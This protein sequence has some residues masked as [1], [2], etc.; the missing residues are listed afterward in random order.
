[1][2][3]YDVADPETPILR[4]FLPAPLDP[5]Y[6]QIAVDGDVLAVAGAT[7]VDLIRLVDGQPLA[8]PTIGPTLTP[9]PTRTPGTEPPRVTPL[10]SRTPAPTITPAIPATA[11]P[12]GSHVYLPMLMRRLDLRAELDT[13]EYEVLRAVIVSQFDHPG[14]TQLV[15]D[16]HTE[17]W[18]IFGSASEFKERIA[19]TW[20]DLA[21][22]TAEMLLER[23]DRRYPL[24]DGFSLPR[25]IVLISEAEQ[26]EIF[27]D[28]GGWEEFYKRYPGAQGIMGLARV[29]FSPDRR[30]AL[31]YVGNQYDWLA[32]VGYLYLLENTADGW[33]ISDSLFLWIS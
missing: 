10:P 2:Y 16:D 1:V 30:W 27:R 15:I 14:I 28:G 19:E 21:E 24:S 4:G 11:A 3:A 6:T 12:P 22:E 25:P 32:G 18:W 9:W 26:N 17:N 23:N 31:A 5:D 13:D 29:G 8:E 20:P 33:E 7:G